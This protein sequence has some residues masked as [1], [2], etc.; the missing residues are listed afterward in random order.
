MLAQNPA[1]ATAGIHRINMS[2][3]RHRETAEHIR[4]E[5]ERARLDFTMSEIETA[6]TLAR[7]AQAFYLSGWAEQAESVRSK[8]WQAYKV[9]ADLLNDFVLND[10]AAERKLRDQ[11]AGKLSRIRAILDQVPIRP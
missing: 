7:S 10:F 4:F 3:S 5:V 9:A 1:Q 2:R 11:M 8:A 6:H